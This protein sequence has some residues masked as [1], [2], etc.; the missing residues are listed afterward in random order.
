MLLLIEVSDTPAKLDWGRKRALYATAG[1][2]EYWVLDL[3]RRVAVVN[4][5]PRGDA[6]R[7]VTEHPAEGKIAPV[8]FPDIVI[9]L[10]PLLG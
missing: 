5:E 4:R 1:I 6:Y 2:P 10:K 7:S 3:A 9:Q 8:A